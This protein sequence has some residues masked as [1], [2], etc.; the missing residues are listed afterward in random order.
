MDDDRDNSDWE[1]TTN[2][3]SFMA[4]EVLGHEGRTD[5]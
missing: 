5:L 1:K 3:R 2:L 4:K